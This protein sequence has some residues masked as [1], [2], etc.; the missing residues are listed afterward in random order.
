MAN[1]TIAI[2]DIHGCADALQSLLD[3]I[4]PQPTDTIITL[5]D[6]IDRGPK[7]SA[8]ISILAD[9]ITECT[10]VPLLGNHEI[11][12][13]NA[14]K[15]RREFEF[16]MYNGGKATLASYDGDMNNMPMH[17]RTFVNFCKPWHE[18]DTHI[19]VHAAYDP[20]LP[21]DQQPDDLLFWRHVDENFLP[22]PHYS[23]KTIICGHTPQTYGDI[24]D[25]GHIKLID[26]FCYGDQWLTAYDV[27]TGQYIQARADGM[28]RPGRSKFQPPQATV[29]KSLQDLPESW[30]VNPKDW[31]FTESNPS[32]L[33]LDGQAFRALN[34]TVAE[35]LGDFLNDL[36]TF[37]VKNSPPTDAETDSIVGR[38]ARP[39]PREPAELE[40]LLDLLFDDYIPASFNTASAG[41]LSYIPGGGLPE[42][43]IGD[44]IASITNRFSS[45]W[46]AAPAMAEI[47]T[48]VIRWF[49]DMVGYGKNAGGFLTTGG[50]IANMA[51]IVAAR[52]K[53][54]SDDFR[55]ARI[56]TS[57][58]SHHC[59]AKAAFIAGFPKPN[60][61][62]VSV[63]SEQR[64]NLTELKQMIDSDRAAGFQPV[65]VVANAGTTNTGAVD[66]LMQVHQICKEQNLWMHVDAAYGGFFMLTEQGRQMMQGI[67]HADS[68]VLD[69][70]K[71]LFL[72]YGT[73][74]LLMKRRDDLTP[75]FSF[76]SDYMPVMT[77]DENRQDFCDISPELSRDHRGLRIWLPLMLHGVGVFESL[78]NEKLELIQWIHE[79]LIEL[80]TDLGKTNPN[81]QIELT[82][83]PQLSILA[84]RL[85]DKNASL[86]QNNE[87]NQS[88][89]E[90]INRD[91]SIMMSST[92]L[93]GKFILR[94]CVLNFRTHIECMQ[95]AI[96][97]IAKSI[98]SILK[99]TSAE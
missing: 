94:I 81:I 6:Y 83:P 44:L 90:E 72:P 85:H 13:T 54:L 55:L 11:M 60:L 98:G 57:E 96:Q 95:R 88:W 70:H 3:A 66:D 58:Q 64:I 41:Y 28:L 92:F 2:G 84:F 31:T 27:E 32:A 23:G 50:S 65:M 37:P 69:P 20:S 19:F 26:T 79:R 53:M 40:D 1:R 15:S 39:I 42:S 29:S 10:L 25:L 78:L 62:R 89:L 68:I 73:G 43:A 22:P 93:D 59:V 35:R 5:G 61:R 47:E 12:M 36:D 82:A 71:G 76:T 63:D 45:A 48:S 18:T 21:M 80:N 4:Q 49:C 56:Y 67:Q 99:T 46:I 24:T 14:L 16:W 87:L 97:V 9:L 52:V 77:G 34:K 51:A 33:E 8:V 17:H 30:Q 38:L 91:G 74:S 75:A 7:S 86:D